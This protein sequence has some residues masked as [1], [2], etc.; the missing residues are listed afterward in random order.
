M[1]DVNCSFRERLSRF[2]DNLC[3]ALLMYSWSFSEDNF[4]LLLKYMPVNFQKCL[5]YRSLYI[6]ENI[7]NNNSK[8]LIIGG[9]GGQLSIPRYPT[10]DTKHGQLCKRKL[11]KVPKR[12]SLLKVI[13]NFSQV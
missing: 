3:K 10:R 2:L 6:P 5:K 13:C 7:G 8:Q 1:I 4:N 9:G 12:N 11:T